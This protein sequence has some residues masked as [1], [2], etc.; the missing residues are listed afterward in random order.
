MPQATPKKNISRE[1]RLRSR[2][3]RG[4]IFLVSFLWLLFTGTVVYLGIFS[5][6]L[7]VATWQATGLSLISEEDFHKTVEEALSERYVGFIPR[8]TFFLVRPKSLERLL[9]ERYPLIREVD[10]RR[11]FPNVL[12]IVVRERD[13][14]VLWCSE[15]ACAHILEDGSTQLVTPL[16]QAEENQTRT[17][18]LMD[19]SEEPLRFGLDVFESDFI[20]LILGLREQM[21]SR[22]DIA[23]EPAIGLVSRF[24]NELRIKTTDGW[25][26]YFS[27]KASAEASL[28][29]LALLLDGEIPK[30]R[31]KD[32]LYIDLRT[33]NRIFY[34][35][36]DGKEEEI[37]TEQIPATPVMKEEKSTKKKK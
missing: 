15:G 1:E 23:I 13:T 21:R 8:N 19:E 11:T 10:V 2:E 4:S 30:E 26:I 7:T 22:F 32:L 18:V 14:L 6:Y 16:Y 20:S 12:K 34:R 9:H 37:K 24:A 3:G 17:L 36:Q 29:A 28:D 5:P 33:E 35:Y 27:T 31:W 25:E